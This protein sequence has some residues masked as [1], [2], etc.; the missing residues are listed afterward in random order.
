MPSS[1]MLDRVAVVRTDVSE[2][3]S[4]SIIR[5]ERIRELGKALVIGN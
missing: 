3:C 1:E 4:A 5:V 2:E